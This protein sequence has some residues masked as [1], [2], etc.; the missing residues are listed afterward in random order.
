MSCSAC[1]RRPRWSR[2]LCSRS[3]AR[4]LNGAAS[5]RVLTC[6]VTHV[7]RVLRVLTRVL[8]SVPTMESPMNQST[9]IDAGPKGLVLPYNGVMPKL[10]K[11]VFLAPG[12]YVM[13][14]VELGDN[15]NIWFGTVIRGDDHRIRIG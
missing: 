1:P 7:L 10:G 15:V 6:V 12:T 5:S 8:I 4:G 2:K 9:M 14:D 11:N 3:R 13:G